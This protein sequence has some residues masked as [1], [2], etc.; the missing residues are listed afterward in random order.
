MNLL[1]GK[2][3][4]R[5]IT[6]TRKGEIGNGEG[7]ADDADDTDGS[8]MLVQD[9]RH[10]RNSRLLLFGLYPVRPFGYFVLS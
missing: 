3:N 9:P 1:Q 2:T 7:T 5:Q 10:P 8:G 6:K 4:C